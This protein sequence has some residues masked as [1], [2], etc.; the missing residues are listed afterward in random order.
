M[1]L[2]YLGYVPFN[3]DNLPE[4]KPLRGAGTDR[5]VGLIPSTMFDIYWSVRSMS[6][7][8]SSY[9]QNNQSAFDVFMIGGGSSFTVAGANA[10]LELLNFVNS[11]NNGAGSFSGN[12]KIQN[13]IS[14][15][16]RRGMAYGA[17][18][19]FD[20][21]IMKKDRYGVTPQVTISRTK[22][23]VNEGTICGA[24]PQH[25]LHTKSGYVF[26]DFSDI[27]FYQGLYWPKILVM[28]GGAGAEYFVSTTVSRKKDGTLYFPTWDLIQAQGGVSFFGHLIPM[29]AGIGLSLVTNNPNLSFITGTISK[30][31]HCCAEFYY[32]GMDEVRCNR[33]EEGKLFLDSIK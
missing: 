13:A 5:P 2:N 9:I 19:P 3:V 31:K 20:T 18:N 15:K 25:F 17:E 1:Y 30:A 28:L 8:V 33:C 24:G 21:T 32:D 11:Q 14:L 29:Y 6:V 7:G 4:R 26:I 10:G 12:T 27:L 22:K 23:N 16:N